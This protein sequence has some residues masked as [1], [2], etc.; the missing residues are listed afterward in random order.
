MKIKW[1]KICKDLSQCLVHGGCSASDS[2]Y[3]LINSNDKHCPL[4]PLFPNGPQLP[5]IKGPKWFCS[6]AI[7]RLTSGF[8]SESGSLTAVSNIG[9]MEKI[10]FK[11][12]KSIFI[13][14]SLVEFDFICFFFFKLYLFV[15]FMWCRQSSE[16]QI[17][18]NEMLELK[19]ILTK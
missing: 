5:R 7:L 2:Y 12:K 16:G 19:Y 15:P 18:F 14:H 8:T 6:S 13:T 10:F 1:S 11:L 9:S 17:L 3:C 4:P